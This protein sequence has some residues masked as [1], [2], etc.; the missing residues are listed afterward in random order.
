MSIVPSIL[1]ALLL[2][3][4]PQSQPVRV[5][6]AT[7]DAIDLARMIARDEG[8]DVTKTTVYSF[9]LLTS[10]E[11]KPFVQGYTTIGF[12][13]NG[14]SRNLIAISDSTGQAIDYNTCEIFDYPDLR[15]FQERMIR[16]SKAKRKTAQEL[17]NDVGCSSPKV[18]NK[19]VSYAKQQYPQTT[20]RTAR[21]FQSIAPWRVWTT[22]FINTTSLAG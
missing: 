21:P 16:L 9:D 10:S 2:L 5:H 3:S 8:Y 20:R 13:I 4:A 6:I 15:P 17:A 18:L 11:G 22:R 19:P 14:N 12:D 7:S 1:L